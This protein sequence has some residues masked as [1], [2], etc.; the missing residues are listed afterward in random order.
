MLPLK[1]AQ[2]YLV[3]LSH[4][5]GVCYALVIGIELLLDLLTEEIG[6]SLFL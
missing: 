6:S 1:L 5:G 4:L 2:N 3:L